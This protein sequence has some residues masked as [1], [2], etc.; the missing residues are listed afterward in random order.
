VTRGQEAHLEVAEASP[1]AEWKVDGIHL[2]VAVLKEPYRA[3]GPQDPLVSR[4]V[5][6]MGVRDVP[7][8]PDTGGI[9][10]EVQALDVDAGAEMDLR[11]VQR[12]TND[13]WANALY[14]LLVNVDP[15]DLV[16]LP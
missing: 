5:V 14:R 1:L 8:L 9:E 11:A 4:C 13:A 3:Q 7:E 10:P 2:A 15:I 16:A 12:I 6:R